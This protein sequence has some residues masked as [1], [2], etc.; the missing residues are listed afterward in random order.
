MT[1]GFIEF[2]DE[3]VFELG[4]IVE[5]LRGVCFIGIDGFYFYLDECHSNFDTRGGEN[6]TILNDERENH[7]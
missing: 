1:A 2:H 5:M 3:L 7:R 4:A 6:Q